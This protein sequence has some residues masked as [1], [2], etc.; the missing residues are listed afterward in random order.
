V[1]SLLRD[2]DYVRRAIGQHYA[3]I[4]VDEFQDTDRIQN[5]ILFFIAASDAVDSCVTIWLQQGR[6]EA[7]SC[8]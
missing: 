5:E 7:C 4:L 2:H 8:S 6:I 3:H 1:R